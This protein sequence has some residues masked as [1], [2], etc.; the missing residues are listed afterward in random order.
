MDELDLYDYSADSE[1]GANPDF[2]E[3]S[4]MPSPEQSRQIIPEQDMVI[5]PERE[6]IAQNKALEG[7]LSYERDIQPLKKEYFR[8]TYGSGMRPNQARQMF[9]QRSAEVSSMFNEEMKSRGYEMQ[10]Q[11]GQAAYE[12]TINNLTRAREEAARDR[13]MAQSM[14]PIQDE[15]A[16][17]MGDPTITRE[18]ALK[19][20]GEIGVKYGDTLARNKGAAAAFNSFQRSL[21]GYEAEKKSGISF[22]EMYRR[23]PVSA[24]LASRWFQQKYKREPSDD[25]RAPIEIAGMAYAENLQLRAKTEQQRKLA[26]EQR[27]LVNDRIDSLVKTVSEAGFLKDDYGRYDRTQFSS[28][29]EREATKQL[30]AIYGTPEEQEEFEKSSDNAEKMLGIAGGVAA[31][32]RTSEQQAAAQREH[33]GKVYLSE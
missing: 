30:V 33:A 22:G 13:E 5:E 2:T 25:D 4:F 1:V 27:K 31:R 24:A 3:S 8:A 19:L 11:R 10:L 14:R 9:A 28:P 23:D 6:R 18:E 32:W 29:Q 26:D 15:L 12:S 17:I 16:A 20:S 21:S 7:A